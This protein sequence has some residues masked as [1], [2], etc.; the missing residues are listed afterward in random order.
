MALGGA[1]AVVVGVGSVGSEIA[2]NLAALGV[3]RL[4]LVDADAV[5]PENVHRHVLGVRHL[6]RKKA[7]ALAEELGTLCPHLDITGVPRRVED[8]LADPQDALLDADLIV[9]AVGDETLE[10][11]LNR[12][13]AGGPPR[14]HTW[15]EPLGVGGH[16]L[17]CNLPD[18]E[19]DAGVGVGCYECLFVLD[20]ALG[21][22]NVAALTA[23]GQVIRRSLAGCAGTFSPFSALDARRTALEAAE[24]GAAVLTGALAETTLLTWR[25]ERTAFEDEG[26]RL[27]RRAALVGAGARARVAGRELARAECPVCGAQAAA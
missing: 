23:P 14:V 13:L 18:P 2:R 8:V 6:W 15:V 27:S 1:T 25:G 17:A 7:A 9:V 19:R 10:R 20:H 4:R 26:Y 5:G 22:V 12:L 11:R 3:G 24:L 21:L 16:V